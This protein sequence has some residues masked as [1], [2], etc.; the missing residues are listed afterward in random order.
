[1]PPIFDGLKSPSGQDSTSAAR[2]RRSRGSRPSLETLES[3]S[4]LS[5]T[6][7]GFDDL[8][9]KTLVT[10]QYDS[11]GVD[12]TGATVLTKGSGLNTLYPPHSG[13][14]VVG[15]TK[16]SN[17]IASASGGTSWSEV[18]GYITGNE[19]IVMTAYQANGTVVGTASSGGANYAGAPTGLKPNIALD[20]KGSGIAYVKFV[21]APTTK[22]I[23]GFTLDDFLF[24]T[25]GTDIAMDSAALNGSNVNFSYHV[26]NDPGPFVVDLYQSQKTTLDSTATLIG[27]QVVTPAKNS[28]GA[29]QFKLNYTPIPSNFHLL[30]V[31]DPQN[32]IPESIETNNTAV[33]SGDVAA[34]SLVWN[35]MTGGADFTY[36]V[37]GG[38]ISSGV[39]VSFYWAKG[40]TFSTGSLGPINFHYDI[41]VGT[42][43]QVNPYGPIHVPGSIMV[44]APSGTTVILAV[45]NA[46]NITNINNEYRHVNYINDVKITYTPKIGFPLSDHT[47]EVI[48]GL[49]RQAGQ[50]NQPAII[51]STIRSPSEQALAMYNNLQNGTS[52]VYKVPGQQV[53]AVYYADKKRGLAQQAILNDM[54]AKIVAVGP[55]N[56]S[57]HCADAAEWAVRQ[58][59]DLAPSSIRNRPLFASLAGN[60]ANGVA[61]YLDPSNNDPAYH[62]E[63]L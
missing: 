61:Y 40:T 47:Q 6:T 25:S 20:I 35:T 15:D 45:I 51:T 19:N 29:G 33:V 28:S 34:Y 1:M 38:D 48:K 43:Q 13:K 39:T 55:Y 18:G 24:Q 14:N 17:I 7:I 22:L 50:G 62:L 26:T 11:L 12:F 30:V 52:P 59:V 57:H 37:I 2:K 5:L 31:A 23:A 53:I 3:R 49:L 9:T 54:T 56:V 16:G 4:L 42:K 32:F 60:S 63:I 8:P 44:N 41:P 27:T 21:P 46:Q 36:Q 58:V 10:N